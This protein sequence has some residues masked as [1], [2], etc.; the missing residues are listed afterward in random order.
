MVVLAMAIRPSRG[1]A[2]L[3]KILKISVD[4]DGFF[5]EAH[6][7]LRPVESMVSGMFL[8]GVAQGPKDIPETV[9]QAS[10][11]A[12]KVLAMFSSDEL[13]HDPIV[14]EVNEEICSGCKLCIPQCPYEARIFDEQKGVVIVNEVLCE[15]CGACIAACPSGAAQQRNFTDEQI[16]SMVDTILEGEK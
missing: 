11:A 1:A 3:A 6:P 14:A 10:G 4:K 13:T 9:S 12:S 2:E 5:S 7:K 15:G 16:L 8:A